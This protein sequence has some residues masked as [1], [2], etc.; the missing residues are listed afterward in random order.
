MDKTLEL[1]KF[2]NYPFRLLPG[3]KVTIW[4][5]YADII[6]QLLEIIE[7]PLAD[8][9]G[10]YEFAIIHGSLGTGKSHALR[11]LKNYIEEVKKDEFQSIVLYVDRLRVEATTDFTAIYRAIMRLLKDKI[12]LVSKKVHQFVEEQVQKS[13]SRASDEVKK[14]VKAQDFHDQELPF[15]YRKMAPS[16]PAIPC[17]LYCIDE[18]DASAMS[19]L[20][21]EKPKV[22]PTKYGLD[23]FID[24]EYDAIR[25][26]S[27]F[28]NLCTGSDLL[29]SGPLFKCFYLFIDEVEEIKDFPTKTVQSINQG[30][31]DLINGCPERFCLLLGASADPA[32][33]EAYFEDDVMTRLSRQLIEIPSLEVDQAVEFL[34]EV[35]GKYRPL[36]E[37]VPPAHPFTE[38][39]LKEIA[40]QTPER[41]PRNLFRSCQTVMQKAIL[42]GNLETKGTIDVDDVAEYII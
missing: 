23:Y 14:R 20:I 21:G 2:T 12:T 19:I 16:Y 31:R 37:E 17:L 15:I 40:L 4:A 36:G 13:Y 39:A 3:E 26:L 5:G 18:G 41:T 30:I 28:I 42:S 7:S 11:Y 32:E 24:T 29:A 6:N 35:M 38:E 22:S 1:G 8:K 10:L 9:V 34:K 27:S 25:S 33:I